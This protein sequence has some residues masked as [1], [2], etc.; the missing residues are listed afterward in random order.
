VQGAIDA[1]WTTLK[2][3]IVDFFQQLC[4]VAIK[5]QSECI[6]DNER[7]HFVL[8]YNSTSCIQGD[9]FPI[10]ELFSQCA[11]L[12]CRRHPGH[13]KAAKQVQDHIER[14]VDATADKRQFGD[15][16]GPHFVRGHSE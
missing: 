7:I 1:K 3:N 10:H 11:I 12:F 15:V 16:P 4:E 8:R 6:S 9:Q 5:Y 13:D 2:C 14:Q